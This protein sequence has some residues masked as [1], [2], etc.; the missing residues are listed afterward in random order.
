MTTIGMILSFTRKDSKYKAIP[1]GY[2]I[3]LFFWIRLVNIHKI[4]MLLTTARA[5]LSSGRIWIMFVFVP[6][7]LFYPRQA[8]YSDG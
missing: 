2:Y 6:D 7:I 8:V 4:T 1:C 5:V 3:I